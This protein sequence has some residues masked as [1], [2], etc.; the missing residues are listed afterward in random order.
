MR[1]SKRL[2]RMTGNCQVRFLE[3]WTPAMG[4]G[5][6]ILVVITMTLGALSPKSRAV[7]GRAQPDF[8]ILIRSKFRFADKPD[9]RR[10]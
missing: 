2:S 6:S 9:G 7:A 10:R 4:S 3:G 1:R 8:L 5:Y